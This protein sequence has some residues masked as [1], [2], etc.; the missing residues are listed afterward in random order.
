[1]AVSTWPVGE[2]QKLASGGAEISIECEGLEWVLG[3]VLGYGRH[4]E[5]VSPDEARIALRE[6]VQQML[7]AA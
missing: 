6:R 1:M 4:A 2:V 3:W 5:I 7:G